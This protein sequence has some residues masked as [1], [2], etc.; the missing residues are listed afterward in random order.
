MPFA[1][2]RT[3]QKVA[4]REEE[5]KEKVSKRLDSANSGPSYEP[6]VSI[7]HRPGVFVHTH[8]RSSHTSFTVLDSE[9]SSTSMS[10]AWIHHSRIDLT[11]NGKEKR[12]E[13]R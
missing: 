4:Q 2:S 11:A 5:D 10:D 6:F 9:C 13:R 12:R 1:V 8:G 3:L 7:L